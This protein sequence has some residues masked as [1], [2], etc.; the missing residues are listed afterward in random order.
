MKI[1]INEWIFHYISS[2]E[3]SKLVYRF[4]QKLWE[5]CDKIVL[6]RS[7]PLMKKIWRLSKDCQYWEPERRTLAKY[8]INSFIKNPHKCVILENHEIRAIPQQLLSVIPS[9]D[10][11]LVE[12]AYTTEDKFI[13]TTDQKLQNILS[14]YCE[15][16]VELVERFLSATSHSHANFYETVIAIKIDVRN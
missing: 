3:K 6:K 16:K 8:F 7:S 10:I 5:K 4:L 13:L 14:S 1:T 9:D 2:Q 12:T 11:Y 15:F